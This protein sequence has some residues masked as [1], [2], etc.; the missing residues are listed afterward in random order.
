MSK[1]KYSCLATNESDNNEKEDNKP[2]NKETLGVASWSLLHTIAVNYPEN[3][4]TE[5][6][7]T[8]RSFLMN[9]AEVYPCKECKDHFQKQIKSHPPTLK[10]Q[11]EF[12]EW[13]CFQHNL[14]NRRLGKKLFNCHKNNYEKRWKSLE[15]CCKRPKIN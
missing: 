1:K 11:T 5:E 14:V 9:F 4:T 8:M 2:L 15:G 10:S 12:Q 6:Q 3:P 13:I 7:K